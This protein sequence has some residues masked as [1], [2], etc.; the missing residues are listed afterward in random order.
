ME[1]I[2]KLLPV[3]DTNDKWKEDWF[4]S[5]SGIQ[6]LKIVSYPCVT[7]TELKALYEKSYPLQ[8]AGPYIVSYAPVVWLKEQLQFRMGMKSEKVKSIDRGFQNI[9]LD[10]TEQ[11]MWNYCIYYHNQIL[12]SLQLFSSS[13]SSSSFSS[14]SSS[15]SLKYS[16]WHSAQI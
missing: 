11:E 13:S 16:H 15:L 10:C 4:D 14:S 1:R 9:Y 8:S 3:Q 6:D 12:S 5:T 2:N 7:E